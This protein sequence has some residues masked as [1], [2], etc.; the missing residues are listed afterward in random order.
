MRMGKSTFCSTEKRR[1][2][3]DE[4]LK[5][6]YSTNQKSL[7]KECRYLIPSIFFFDNLDFWLEKMPSKLNA[8]TVHTVY[9]ISIQNDDCFQLLLFNDLILGNMKMFKLFFFAFPCELRFK[10]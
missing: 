9:N 8:M 7:S 6:Y 10:Y 2:T 5:P 4:N 1:I 3:F